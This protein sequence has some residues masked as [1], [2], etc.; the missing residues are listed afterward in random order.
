LLTW[1]HL[2]HFV[3][4]CWY[5]FIRVASHPQVINEEYKVNIL[6][7]Y[8]LVLETSLL[9]LYFYLDNPDLAS[10]MAGLLASLCTLQ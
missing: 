8:V 5:R 1:D 7:L 4:T 9:M 2:F 10:C 6:S 3:P